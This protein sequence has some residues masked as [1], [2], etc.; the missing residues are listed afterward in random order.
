MASDFESLV[1]KAREVRSALLL[2]GQ[3]AEFEAKRVISAS[4]LTEKIVVFRELVIQG[5][6]LV[7][8]RISEY[9]KTKNYNQFKEALDAYRDLSE[10]ESADSN[11]K[12]EIKNKIVGFIEDFLL[13]A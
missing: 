9:L 8:P 1:L 4:E 5:K 3:G 10:R 13:S 6:I 12:S 7:G 11:Q 2:A